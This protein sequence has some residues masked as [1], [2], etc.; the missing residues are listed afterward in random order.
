MLKSYR[1]LKLQQILVFI[2]YI[3]LYQNI[4]NA[5]QKPESDISYSYT[6]HKC[7]AIT[8]TELISIRESFNNLIDNTG[9]GAI[10][11]SVVDSTNGEALAFGNVLIKELNIGASTDSRGYFRIPSITSNKT[12]TLIVSYVGYET[13]EIS[14]YI[15]PDK[16]TDINIELSPKAIQFKPVEKIGER[17]VEKNAT[18][19]GL[20][21]ISI[22][23]LKLMPKGVEMDIFRS[24][25]Y[26][27]GVQSTGDVSARYYVRGGSSNENLVILNGVTLYN[28]FHALGLFSVIDPDMI[29]NVEFYKGGFT[30]EYGG[31]LSSVLNVITKDGNKK[32]YSTKISSSFI[33][34]K[35]LIEGP[36]PDGS[37]IVTGRKS[38]KSSNVYKKFLDEKNVPIN[39][40]DLGFKLNYSSPKFVKG[41]KFV[42]H[43]FSSQ[44]KLNNN[45]SLQQDINWSNKMFGLR[46]FQVTDIP[47][48]Y[49]IGL[50]WS[51]FEGNVVPNL[52]DVKP[53]SNKVD[54]LSMN[55]HFSYI[56]ESKN[57]LEF[58]L[59]LSDIDTKLFLQNSLGAVSD[60]GTHGTSISIFGKYKFLETENFGADFGTRLNISTLSQSENNKLFFEPRLSLTYR[61][62]P[63]L[64]LKGAWGIY[65]QEI[66]TLS[67]ENEVI[68]VFEPWIITPRYIPASSAIHYTIG[69]KA[70]ITNNFSIDIQGYYKILKNIPT[71][72]DNKI[73]SSDS[74]LLPA[75]GESYGWEFLLIFNEEPFSLTTSYSLGWSYKH[76]NGWTYY[77]RYDTRNTV[78][79]LGAINLGAG[80]QFSIMWIYNTGRPFTQSLGYYDKL[81]FDDLYTAG[82]LLENF[83]PFSILSDKNLGR[84]PQYHRL[85][86]SLSKSFY[87]FGFKFDL[88]GSIINLYDRANIFYFDR[89]T[90]RRINMLPFLPT[91]TVSIEI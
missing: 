8:P 79:I 31:R 89:N 44:D 83:K 7:F 6:N 34:G 15:A 32:D 16:I 76:L 87:F 55:M 81:Y 9:N 3:C 54:D 47:L 42:I 48:F 40:Y 88:E 30:A 71:I 14:V 52:S 19:I 59:D 56:F 72:N 86:L 43:G 62:F 22:K 5:S 53:K 91:A 66:T 39:F 12:Y 21:R 57:E 13:K 26:L 61:L 20:Q 50:S 10:R 77:P 82:S 63:W 27:P 49:E 29:N 85:D 90:G 60:I 51:N 37:F 24:I 69:T 2:L 28:P 80:W 67:D 36:I 74:D 18:D 23:D 1:V 73:V 70:E 4:L 45:N 84:L 38:Y 75:S 35:A 64:A 68:S 41:G 33:T 78:D 65:S 25:Q 17:M 11:G 58:G 46:W